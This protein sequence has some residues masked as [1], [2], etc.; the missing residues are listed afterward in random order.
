M[1]IGGEQFG[2]VRCIAEVERL[3]SESSLIAPSH[4]CRVLAEGGVPGANEAP[5]HRFSSARNRAAV[6]TSPTRS[7]ASAAPVSAPRRPGAPVN[8]N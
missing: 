3:I 7:A 2:K 4:S 1:K 6:R 5:S 8:A